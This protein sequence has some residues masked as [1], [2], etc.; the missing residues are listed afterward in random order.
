M[1]SF[2]SMF[3]SVIATVSLVTAGCATPG[4]SPTDVRLERK[5]SSGVEIASAHLR[6]MKDR[7]VLYGTVRRTVGY[8]SSM[9]SHLDVEV[10]GS[11]GQSLERLTID[12][13]PRPIPRRHRLPKHS[14]Y[15]VELSSVPPRGGTVRVSHHPASKSEC[16]IV[17]RQ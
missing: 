13:I 5:S 16:S 10:L 2:C 12:Y 8:G 14:D 11:D 3:V 4:Q 15:A 9:R 1:K 7:V 6:K 17:T